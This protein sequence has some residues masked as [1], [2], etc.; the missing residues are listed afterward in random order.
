MKYLYLITDRVWAQAP[1]GGGIP[2]LGDGSPGGGV[3][4]SILQNP[5]KNGV[6]SITE[7]IVA[8]LNLI[9]QIMLP[10]VVLSIVYAG[11][12]YV[13]ARGDKAQLTR[14]H[15]AFKYAVIGAFVVLGG[16]VLVSAIQGTITSLK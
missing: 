15:T 11:F 8:I 4:N 6:D 3:S 10:V 1:G 14:A 12:L 5:L 16:G 7:L 9:M 2:N 13:T